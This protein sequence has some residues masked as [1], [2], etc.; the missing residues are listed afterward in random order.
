MV[1]V[2]LDRTPSTACTA[3]TPHIRFIPLIGGPLRLTRESIGSGVGERRVSKMSDVVKVRARYERLFGVRPVEGSYLQQMEAELSVSLPESFLLATTFLDGSGFSVLPFHAVARIPATNVLSETK[4][5]R[6]SIG[7]PDKF[8]VLGEP[9]ESLLVLDCSNDK[10]L[11]CD[12][13]DAPRLGKEQLTGEPKTWATFFD[14]LCY[15]L[16]EEEEDSSA[17]A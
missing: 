9:P 15:V 16:D 10:V 4:R 8:L 13:V 7:L 6:A 2:G 1:S 14:F 12:A 5:L 3:K 17:R 11:W